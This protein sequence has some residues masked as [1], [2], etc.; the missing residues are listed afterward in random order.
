MDHLQSALVP[1]PIGTKAAPIR[2][3]TAMDILDTITAAT[4]T[5]LGVVAVPI[6]PTFLDRCCLVD[7]LQSGHVPTPTGTK[8]AP[9]RIRTAMDILDTITA[10][11]YTH[12]GVVVVPIIPTFL[13]RCCLVDHLQS[14]LV[15]TPIGTKAARIRI[16]TAMDIRTA[17][18]KV[19]TTTTA[20]YTHLAA[21]VPII[22]TVMD[23]CSLVDHL[24]S[25]HVPT[26]T[27]TQVAPIRIRTAMDTLTAQV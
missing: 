15:P 10:A 3:R 22:L 9:I 19:D 16:R 24:Q 20:T 14:D 6:I 17:Q 4:Y 18:V 25:G 12:L 27:G 11:T 5:H 7:H 23:Q 26:P 13:D 8:V 1:T 21:V 2:I